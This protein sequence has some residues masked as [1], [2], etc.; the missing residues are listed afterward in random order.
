MDSFNISEESFLELDFMMH[1]TDCS[2][3]DMI[4]L[5]VIA[6]FEFHEF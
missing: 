6:A 4:T 2:I 1:C 3:V 5:Y